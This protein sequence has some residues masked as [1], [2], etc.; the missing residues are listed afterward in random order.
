M[1]Q[2]GADPAVDKGEGAKEEDVG[3]EGHEEEEEE[4][5]EKEEDARTECFPIYVVVQ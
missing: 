2:A 1:R 5:K 3:K 4:D